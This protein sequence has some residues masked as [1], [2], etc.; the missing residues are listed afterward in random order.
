MKKLN[1][2]S[3]SGNYK[4]ETENDQYN[5]MCKEITDVSSFRSFLLRYGLNAEKNQ[6]A[7]VK[8]CWYGK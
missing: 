6:N 4:F 5:E 2:Q 1:L 8:V 3:V 7:V